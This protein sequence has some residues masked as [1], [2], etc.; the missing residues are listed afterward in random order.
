MYENDVLA[1]GGTFH[2]F[3][4]KS[5]CI[6]VVGYGRPVMGSIGSWNIVHIGVE[7]P[8]SISTQ[9]YRKRKCVECVD[10]CIVDHSS[11]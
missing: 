8:V 2:C 1:C 6:T 11:W 7:Y 4:H 5:W 9:L 3:R 10:L